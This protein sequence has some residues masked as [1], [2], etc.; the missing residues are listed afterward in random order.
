MRRLIQLLVAGTLAVAL[1]PVAARGQQSAAPM[2]HGAEVRIQAK[3]WA[4][5]EQFLR[6]EAIPAFPENAELWYWLGVV[7][8]Q[9]TSRNTEEATAAFA[10]AKELADP[11]EAELQ[12]K[13]DRA[14]QAIW[15]PTV[16]AAAKALEAG[17]VAKAQSLLEQAVAI[18][19]EGPEAW[20]NLGTVYV[21]QEKH[22]E[23]AKAYEK[24]ASLEPENH[25]LLYNL[26]ITYHQL[27]RE[28]VAAGDSAAAAAHLDKAEATYQ[29]YLEKNPGDADI[30]NNLASLYQERGEEEKMRETLGEVAEADSVR[31]EDVYNAGRAFLKGEDY[32]RAEQAFRQTIELTNPNDPTSVEAQEFA[33]EYLGLVLIQQK[34]Y[35]E[36]IEVLQQLVQ[37]KPENATAQ[38]YL[39]FAYRDSG[40]K[41]EAAAAFARAEELRSQG[42][43][44][45][46]VEGG[47]SSAG[48]SQP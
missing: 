23:A 15:G 43:G 31:Q 11:E 46:A 36:A 4:E 25:T 32:A 29:A 45:G 40:R 5:A 41:E 1:A 26:G 39:G 14:V 47:A 38:E 37:R 30:I 9:G 6:E 33:M 44:T 12:E 24:A 10:K 16:N 19:P 7:Y 13:I 22:A 17:D 28:A 48:E 34:K 21:R 3:K 20:I 18:N 42:G 35:D 2:I 8:A 27:G